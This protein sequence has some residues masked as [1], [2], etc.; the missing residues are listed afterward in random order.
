MKRRIQV[1]FAFFFLL[2]YLINPNLFADEKTQ[3]FVSYELENF[4]VDPL[5]R[6]VVRGDTKFLLEGYPKLAIVN[7]WP[8]ALYGKNRDGKTY[9]VLGIKCGFTRQGYNYLEII[10]AKEAAADTAEN[11]IIL[12]DEN[13]KKW[14][15]DPV[16]FKGRVTTFDIWVWGSN[17]NYYLEAHLEDHMGIVHVL[18]LGDLLYKGW[19]NLSIGIPS[20]ISQSEHYVPSLKPLSLV[21][22]M[23]W[24]RPTEKVDAFYIYLDQMKLL[25]D[26]FESSFDGDDLVDT[27]FLDEI[28]KDEE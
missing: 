4:D 10:P 14:V 18:K 6:W 19:R 9:N 20:S 15:S 8:E 11:K 28:W 7:T 21:K 12:T 22:L 5:S 3:S 24:T 27:T 13:G 26:M 17:H 23:L 2:L 16:Q 25:T 1:Y